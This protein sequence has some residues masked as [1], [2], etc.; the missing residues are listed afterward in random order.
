MMHLDFRNAYRVVARRETAIPFR[1]LRVPSG[2]EWFAAC[3]DAFEAETD[4]AEALLIPGVVA[5]I[6]N[7]DAWA[8]RGLTPSDRVAYLHLDD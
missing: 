1:A 7:E 3:Q 5:V 2:D 6:R 4:E 8:K